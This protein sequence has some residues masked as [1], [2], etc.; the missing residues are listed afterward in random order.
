MVPEERLDDI[1]Q[2]ATLT[3]GY[4]ATDFC[5]AVYSLYPELNDSVVEN[6]AS[7]MGESLKKAEWEAGTPE[8]MLVARIK[9]S[10]VLVVYGSEYSVEMMRNAAVAEYGAQ[11]IYY[12][13]SFGE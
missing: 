13:N 2:V 5:S 6:F 4:V 7:D 10:C 12:T 9:D 8:W 3:D 1:A 11:V